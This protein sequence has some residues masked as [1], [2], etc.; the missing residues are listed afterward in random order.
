MVVLFLCITEPALEMQNIQKYGKDLDRNLERLHKKNLKW[1]RQL[2]EDTSTKLILEELREKQVRNAG[3]WERI[4]TERSEAIHY[5]ERGLPPIWIISTGIG[6]TEL[7]E[8][9]LLQPLRDEVEKLLKL[10]KLAEADIGHWKCSKTYLDDLKEHVEFN[11]SL[12]MSLRGCRNEF[13]ERK[14]TLKQNIL[15]LSELETFSD[16]CSS[17]GDV[18]KKCESAVEKCTKGI[19]NYESRINTIKEDMNKAEIERKRVLNEVIKCETQLSTLITCLQKKYDRLQQ[20]M[21]EMLEELNSDAYIARFATAHAKRS[22]QAI[23]GGSFLGTLAVIGIGVA[24]GGLG[25][26]AGAYTAASA[27]GRA[28][29]AAK[30]DQNTKIMGLRRCQ[31]EIKRCDKILMESNVEIGQMRETIEANIED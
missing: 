30:S 7:S 25:L 8:S 16:D 5:L 18:I 28:Y 15:Y 21:N 22:V 23:G 26:A 2:K 9:Q 27:G 24:T 20:R 13:L 3:E 11:K 10:A 6:M 17:S 1:L 19:E 4:L 29:E 12:E 31:D 14:K